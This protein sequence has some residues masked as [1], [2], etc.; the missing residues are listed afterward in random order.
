M[1]H[2]AETIGVLYS[3]KEKIQSAPKNRTRDI[4]LP[5]VGLLASSLNFSASFSFCISST[6]LFSNSFE[7]WTMRRCW[8][9]LTYFPGLTSWRDRDLR[10]FR[11][12]VSMI[13]NIE[14]W[15]WILRNNIRNSTTK[16]NKSIGKYY[17]SM[18][19]KISQI[20]KYVKKS[21]SQKVEKSI[22]I[23]QSINQSINQ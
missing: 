23:N 9:F 2:H 19:R 16:V 20:S 4:C 18:S 15:S 6:G 12:C 21:R 22:K 8:A 10:S 3:G 1:A 5:G 13:E 14:P 17:E 7:S 11:P